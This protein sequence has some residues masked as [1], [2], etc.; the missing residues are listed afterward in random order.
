MVTGREEGA[1]FLVQEGFVGADDCAHLIET[2]ERNIGRAAKD[3]PGSHFFDDRYMWFTSLPRSESR[4]RRVM[5][6]ARHRVVAK[7]MQF[8]TEPSPV[9]S[10]SIQLVKWP[11]GPGM[12]SHADNAHPNGSLHN[13]PWRKYASVVYLNEDY[14]GGEFFFTRMRLKLKPRTGMLV[15][16]R[17]GFEHEHGVAPVTR[18]LRY[19]MPAWY[20]TEAR[21]A[22]RSER[23]LV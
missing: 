17:G 15:I 23:E 10:D 16:F 6:E 19:T 5:Q 4:A 21:R 2:F 9:Y 11:V 12:P 20:G 13:T 1:D 18:G 22:D 14:D 7:I 3:A 8:Y